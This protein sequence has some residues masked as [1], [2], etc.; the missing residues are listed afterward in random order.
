MSEFPFCY[1]IIKG[2]ICG[3][4]NPKKFHKQKFHKCKKCTRDLKSEDIIPLE[5]F[6]MLA[7]NFMKDYECD[8]TKTINF[9]KKI[10]KEYPFCIIKYS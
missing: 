5:F 8:K 2:S 9:Y 6:E 4:S 3:E 10:L 1:N 7:K